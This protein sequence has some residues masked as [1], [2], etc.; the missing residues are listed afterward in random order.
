MTITGGNLRARAT[1]PWGTRC[2]SKQNAHAGSEDMHT[3]STAMEE[4]APE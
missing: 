2:L 3:H 1:F 4:E